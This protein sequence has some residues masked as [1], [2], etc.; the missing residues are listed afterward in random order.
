VTKLEAIRHVKLILE[1]SNTNKKRNYMKATI[2]AE[3]DEIIDRCL[4]LLNG[5]TA[6]LMAGVNGDDLI[7][8]YDGKFISPGVT[9]RQHLA[10]LEKW[11][12]LR[13]E[14]NKVRFK[15]ECN[16]VNMLNVAK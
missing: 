10:E 5:V 4:G 14:G 15:D 11:G 1:K 6:A 13:H 7:R 8:L 16:P 2:D 9:I 12:C 3:I